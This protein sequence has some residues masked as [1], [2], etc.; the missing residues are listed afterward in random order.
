[1]RGLSP[2][3]GLVNFVPALPQKSLNLLSMLHLREVQAV[4]KR[5]HLQRN[6]AWLHR[7]ELKATF[8]GRL[9]F[10]KANPEMENLPGGW[11][12]LTWPLF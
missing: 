3:H 12:K 11:L 1:M 5:R 2:D 6:T 10:R 9:G 8:C 7:Y 4:K